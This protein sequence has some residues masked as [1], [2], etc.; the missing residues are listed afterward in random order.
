MTRVLAVAGREL[1]ASFES[2]AAYVTITFFVLVQSAL[3]FFVGYPVG[4]VPLPGL[5]EGGQASLI[6]LFTWLP[7]L[8]AFLVPALTMGAFAEERRSGT[9][10]LLFTWPVRTAEVV[11]GKFLAAWALLAAA[12]AATVLPVAWTVAGL[13]DL[14]WPA[15]LA[16][17]C[18]A[19]LLAAAYAAIALAVSAASEEQLV[20]YLV[21]ALLLGGLW[22]LRLAVA[23]VPAGLAPAL[24]YA[25]P[26]T[27]F[28]GGAARGVL[29]LRDLAYFV[30]LVLLG[31]YVSVRLVDRRRLGG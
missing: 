21:S 15:T 1:G 11:V 25:A 10:E 13:G 22:A 31:L 2:P 14:D 7:L 18:G 8:F 17:L 12:L 6:V 9:Q 16:G 30:L 4:R 29:D 19:S 3:V 5:W 23:L 28:L 26:S 27:H 20:A 24:E